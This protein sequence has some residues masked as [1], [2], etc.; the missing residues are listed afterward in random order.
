M[1]DKIE[2]LSSKQMIYADSIKSISILGNTARIQFET[3]VRSTIDANNKKSFEKENTSTVVMPIIALDGLY[4]ILEQLK[5]QIK[6]KKEQ[7]KNN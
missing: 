3:I 7:S 5:N 6:E 4:N 1:S 2:E